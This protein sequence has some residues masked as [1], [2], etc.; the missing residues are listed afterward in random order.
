MKFDIIHQESYSRGQLLLRAFFGWLYIC[1]PHMFCLIFIGMASGILQ[2]ITFWIILFTGKFPVDFFNFQVK[3]LRWQTR[4]N[5]SILNLM[6]PYPEFGLESM[7]EGITLDI[8]YQDD[9]SRSDVLIR[10]L[11]GVL[12]VGI[13]HIFC[14]IFRGIA[15]DILIFISFWAVLF[16]GKYPSSWHKFN[17]GTLRWGIRV[18]AYLAYLTHEY[19]PFSGK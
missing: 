5:A 1:I 18:N 6:D 13:P 12:Y 16:T 3:V 19:P 2:F 15:S 8:P 9:I 10:G 11:F 4:V 17:V 7:Q 14:L